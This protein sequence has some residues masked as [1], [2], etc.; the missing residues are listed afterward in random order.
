[1]NSD[2]ASQLAGPQDPDHRGG[3][4]VSQQ[5]LL[6]VDSCFTADGPQTKLRKSSAQ[7]DQKYSGNGTVSSPLL[8]GMCE[9]QTTKPSTACGVGR[10][11]GGDGATRPRDK[12]PWTLDLPT[13][14]R[15][16]RNETKGLVKWGNVIP[17]PG[18][19]T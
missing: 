7:R 5:Y 13:G 2:H 16:S 4:T 6:K 10:E 18:H 9:C 12:D 3:G 15:K 11:P 17:G 8:C 19:R 14:V 1:M